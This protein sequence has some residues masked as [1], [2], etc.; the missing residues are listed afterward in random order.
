MVAYSSSRI[1][2]PILLLITI[3]K[4]STA[5]SY[6]PVLAKDTAKDP[7]TAEPAATVA[8]AQLN[9]ILGTLLTNIYNIGMRIT[10]SSH[11]QKRKIP[12]TPETLADLAVTTPL[13][14]VTPSVTSSEDPETLI[15]DAVTSETSKTIIK[16][17]LETLSSH[18]PKYK[19]SKNHQK[20]A[21][22]AVTQAAIPDTDVPASARRSSE[23]MWIP[24]SGPD[25]PSRLLSKYVCS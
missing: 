14:D 12:E 17:L 10:L 1:W 7:V 23:F 11:Q 15:D 16:T 8:P 3:I 6:S 2:I 20:P 21:K 9:N 24:A 5:T 13:Q 4:D 22:Q 18:Q 25:E 19:K